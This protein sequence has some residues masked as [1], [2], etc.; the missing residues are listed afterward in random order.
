MHPNVMTRGK[1]VSSVRVVCIL[2]LEFVLTE[3]EQDEGVLGFISSTLRCVC[4]N[5]SKVCPSQDFLIEQG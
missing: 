1:G 5:V 4:A 2:P 3:I